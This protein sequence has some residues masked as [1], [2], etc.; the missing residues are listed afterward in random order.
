M[1]ANGW[2]TIGFKGDT[3]DLEKDIKKTEQELLKYEKEAE[4]LAKV[5]LKAETDLQAYEE[6]KQAIEEFTNK[7]LEYAQTRQQVNSELAFEK[8]LIDE[9]NEKY[10]KQLSALN[11]VN[12]KI[13][14]N[15]QKQG[16]LK[17]KVEE[18]TKE[19]QKQQKA[20]DLKGVLTGV[21]SE[22]NRVVK[23]VGKW[24]LA[25]F[26]IRTA[27]NLVRQVINTIASEDGQIATDLE[28]MKWVLAQTLKPVVEWLVQALYYVLALIDNIASR[29]FNINI[30]TG[31]SADDF[32]KM[33]KST[34]GISKDLKEANKQLAGFDE[35]N[36]I[37]DN[38]KTG[39][40]GGGFSID[41]WIPPD[42][43]KKKKQIE[44]VG[45]EFV[46]RYKQA[47]DALKNMSLQDWFKAFGEWGLL[48]RGI[49]EYF[50]GL[51][52]VI[53]GLGTIAKGVIDTIVGIFTG[54]S[55]KIEEGIKEIWEGIKLY[56][57]GVLH[58][59]VGQLEAF[60][61]GV[62]GIVLWLWNKITGNSKTNVKDIGNNLSGIPKWIDKNL[63]KPIAKF[64]EGLWNGLKEGFNTAVNWIKNLFN[65]LVTFF[66]GIVSKILSF[67]KSIGTNV[68]NAIGGAFKGAINGVLGAI[69]SILNSPIRAINKLI[70]TVNNIPG[71]NLGKLSTFS[72]PRLAKGGIVNMPGRGVPVG[73]AIAGER[74]QEAVL[75]LT[76]SQQMD[77]LGEA[78]G[79]HITIN[80]TIP[81]YA[82]N[83]KVDQ[84]IKRIKAEDDF[85][86]NR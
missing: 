19:Y 78:I 54:D 86:F 71:V 12:K 23:N 25:I 60:V 48:V 76:D 32:K 51:T 68:G 52:Q 35:M 81:V 17:T 64:F 9:L 56:F 75:P 70:S 29:I 67:F 74:G 34:G 22:M 15:A 61:G 33:K 58:F 53:L 84:Q 62:L 4:K 42:I 80:A 11:D 77:L 38:T 40:A 24:A 55:K 57:E 50:Y 43:G 14:E 8:Q 16:L 63:I 3:T 6:E 30:L 47:Q 66:N 36:V 65:G 31:K 5:K 2:V 83:R 79:K 1:N 73:S 59:F 85:A 49:V 41:D 69:E 82:Y 7:S 44:E 13:E 45:N 20:S 21:N 26:G 18:T 72:F 28:Y 27:Y 37:A 39:S 46:K 10:S